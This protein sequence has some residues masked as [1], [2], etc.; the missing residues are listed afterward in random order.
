MKFKISTVIKAML[1][2]FRES[3]Y[4]LIGFSAIVFLISLNILA[5]N[6]QIYFSFQNFNLMKEI[7]IGTFFTLPKHSVVLLFVLSVLSGIFISMFAYH[8]KSSGMLSTSS[9]T[10]TLGTILGILAPSCT[11]CG[12]GLAAA[13]GFSGI[14]GT[15]PFDGIELGIVGI[16]LLLIAIYLLSTRIV[17]KTCIVK[18]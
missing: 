18:G 8:V 12:I 3:R 10:G 15:L 5:V 9:K 11:T 13:L 17:E 1:E 16:I 4:W 6:Y 7:F 2:V 14:I